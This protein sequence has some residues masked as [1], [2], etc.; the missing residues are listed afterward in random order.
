MRVWHSRNFYL[1]EVFHSFWIITVAFSA[2]PFYF[3]DLARLASGLDVLKVDIW[4]LAEVH[5]RAQEIE[6]AWRKRHRERERHKE[7]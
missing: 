1:Q 6:Q 5:N 4:V 7:S 2:N 3:F